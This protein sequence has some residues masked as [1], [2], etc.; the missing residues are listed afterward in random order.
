[1]MLMMGGV[2]GLFERARGGRCFPAAPGG[3]PVAKPRATGRNSLSRS[4]DPGASASRIRGKRAAAPEPEREA[5]EAAPLSSLPCVLPWQ[6]MKAVAARGGKSI[7]AGGGFPA[8][9]RRPGRPMRP[10]RGA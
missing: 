6:A 9:R 3:A 5:R 7:T 8:A 2:N 10:R 4:L 1:M